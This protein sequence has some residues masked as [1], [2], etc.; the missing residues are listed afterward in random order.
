MSFVG[1]VGGYLGL[2]VGLSFWD[3]YKVLSGLIARFALQVHMRKPQS[4]DG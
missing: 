1:E 2:F 3:I 4:H